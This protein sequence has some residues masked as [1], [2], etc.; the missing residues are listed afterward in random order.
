MYRMASKNSID[1]SVCLLSRAN[2]KYAE[3]DNGKVE[4]QQRIIGLQL[5]VLVLN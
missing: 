3:M 2:D 1:E 4:N 5:K